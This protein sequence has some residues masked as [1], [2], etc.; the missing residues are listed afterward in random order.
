MN[1]INT[2]NKEHIK[3]SLNKSNIII[4]KFKKGDLISIRFILSKKQKRKQTFTGVCTSY[5]NKG[6]RSSITLYNVI[7]K[8]GVTRTFPLYSS[9]ILNISNLNNK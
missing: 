2:L 5:K 8:Q 3:Q 9:M 6:F 1:I 4:P 7:Y